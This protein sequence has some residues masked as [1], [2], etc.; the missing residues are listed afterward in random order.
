MPV[1]M[2]NGSGMTLTRGE[3]LS[4]N[5]TPDH[6]ND[7]QFCFPLDN[8][9]CPVI[10]YLP[11]TSSLRSLPCSWSLTTLS[12]MLD[13]PWYEEADRT[14]TQNEL[15]DIYLALRSNDMHMPQVSGQARV[16]KKD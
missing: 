8:P 1:R 4:G 11:A 2:G 5:P 14:K 6:N 10:E 3:T 16:H 13:V 7:I 9:P 15:R 12:I